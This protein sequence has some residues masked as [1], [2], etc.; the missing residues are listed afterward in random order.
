MYAFFPS[1][2]R[3][4]SFAEVVHILSDNQWE[5][6]FSI[7]L[8]TIKKS[9][10]YDDGFG[11]LC[12]W[13]KSILCDGF[14]VSVTLVKDKYEQILCT[15]NDVATE[16]M[17]PSAIFRNEDMCYFMYFSAFSIILCVHMYFI[18]F[19]KLQDSFVTYIFIN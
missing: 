19:D 12:G 2:Y 13:L 14:L 11:E 17:I 9:V 5:I 4:L 1:I 15:K 16:V 6:I 18:P 8:M 3:F 7:Q 10:L